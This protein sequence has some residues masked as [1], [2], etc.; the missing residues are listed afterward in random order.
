[1]LFLKT[2][3][4]N[5]ISKIVFLDKQNNSCWFK[6]E[7]RGFKDFTL[8]NIAIGQFHIYKKHGKNVVVFFS[9][10]EAFLYSKNSS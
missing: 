10:N 2:Q 1:M 8:G 7:L 4:L 5:V 6:H 3:I 9:K